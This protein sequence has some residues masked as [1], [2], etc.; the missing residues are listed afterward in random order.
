[1]RQTT[2]HTA[3]ILVPKEKKVSAKLPV[4]YNPVMK[5]NR[6][7]T[8]LLINCIEEK[9][10][11]AALPLA[12]TGVR[13]IRLLK[14]TGKVK[15]VYMNDLNEKAVE[16]IKKN[17][18]LNKIKKSRYELHNTDANLFLLESKGFD[19]ID[20]DPFGSPNPFLDSAVRR[21]SRKSILAV[22]ATDTAPLCGTYPK[23]CKRK[24][25]A[26]PARNDQMH[27]IGLRILIRKV[28]LIGAQYE[29]ALTPIFSYYKDHYFRI[30]FSVAKGK[31][32]VDSVIKK[33]DMFGDA[34]PLWT[35]NLWD[36]NIT[37]KMYN[38]N[39]LPDNNTFLRKVMEESQ[40]ETCGFYDIHGTVKKHNIKDIPKT[41]DVIDTIKKKGYHV[42]LTH[43]SLVG[44]RT[45]MPLKK[46]ITLLRA[47]KR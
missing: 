2:E 15:K 16:N 6:D 20:I 11:T 46:F 39:T 36:K 34:G 33:H 14:E 19:Y 41:N 30:F 40:I 27:E 21:L 4:F 7:M 12:G 9:D 5:F 28:Q 24:Y 25:W 8:V 31:K 44:L 42:S 43:F 13:G 26:T 35:G 23:T 32:K 17:L 29:R 18:Q 1:M 45:D 22:T 47:H 38:S 3:T 37:K 10:I